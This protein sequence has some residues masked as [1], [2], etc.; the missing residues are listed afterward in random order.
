M[1]TG[2]AHVPS[3]VK[4]AGDIYRR[5]LGLEAVKARPYE[6]G[7]EMIAVWNVSA[8]SVGLESCLGK[9]LPVMLTACEPFIGK[10]AREELTVTGPDD[11]HR[12]IPQ[13]P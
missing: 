5:S 4:P 12:R 13:H 10:T 1:S 8:V 11:Y 7:G 3:A 2:S 6:K 9:I